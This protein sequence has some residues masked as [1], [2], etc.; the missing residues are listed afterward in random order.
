MVNLAQSFIKETF[1]F[2]VPLCKIKFND[3]HISEL[4]QETKELMKKRNK[5]RRL[6][7]VEEYKK[8]RNKCNKLI[9]K[10]IGVK[11]LIKK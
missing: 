1:E 3:K 5:E 9:K 2:N 6:G 7:N 4:Q 8:L 10:R 11:V